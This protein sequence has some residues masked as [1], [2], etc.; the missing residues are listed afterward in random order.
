M[1][2][3]GLGEHIVKQGKDRGIIRFGGQ[4]KFR[5]FLNKEV[6]ESLKQKK[7]IG[8]MSQYQL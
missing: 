1:H 4:V 5:G 7:Y 8:Q 6:F 2:T 3:R